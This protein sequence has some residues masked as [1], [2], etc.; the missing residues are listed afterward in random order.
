MKKIYF[1]IVW[2]IA[3]NVSKAQLNNENV[4]MLKELNYLHSFGEKYS[5]FLDQSD[6]TYT[7]AI[8]IKPSIESVFNNKL[9]DNKYGERIFVFLE[10]KINDTISFN[11]KTIKI[12]N[13]E[14][15][16]KDSSLIIEIKE[17]LAII[18]GEVLQNRIKSNYF[19]F[20]FIVYRRLS[21]P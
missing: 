19:G 2:C 17:S 1:I 4:W 15:V 11:V 16:I 12:Y 9:S 6:N 8:L 5:I 21:Q 20:G 3:F 7:K 10:G 18:N 13:D 14:A